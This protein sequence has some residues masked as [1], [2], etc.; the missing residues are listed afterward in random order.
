MKGMYDYGYFIIGGP[1]RIYER[2]HRD[3]FE[4]TFSFNVDH[5]PVD[6]HSNRFDAD[7]FMADINESVKNDSDSACADDI[8]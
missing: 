8:W 6:W 1:F 7:M 5:R 4:I 2:S 3:R